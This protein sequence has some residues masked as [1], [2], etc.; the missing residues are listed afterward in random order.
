M[1]FSSFFLLIGKGATFD[2]KQLLEL[3]TIQVVNGGLKHIG[4]RLA[5]FRRAL[6]QLPQRLDFLDA[7]LFESVK[8]HLV[9]NASPLG[10]R[11]EVP[12][13]LNADMELGLMVGTDRGNG[14]FSVQGCASANA[15]E[16]TQ[17]GQWTKV[18]FSA[19]GCAWPPVNV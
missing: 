9:W 1:R 12:G 18:H 14:H 17:C 16:T 5:L 7:L 4:R 6:E 2:M 8:S 19:P 15:K 3:L 11:I 10:Q 13:K